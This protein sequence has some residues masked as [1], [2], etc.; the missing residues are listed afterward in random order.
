METGGDSSD[1]WVDIGD[2]TQQER[3]V[4]SPIR[5]VAGAKQELNVTVGMNGAKM[6][7]KRANTSE[8]DSALNSNAQNTCVGTSA[9]MSA[10]QTAHNTLEGYWKSVALPSNASAGDW[11]MCYKPHQ[12]IWSTVLS[13]H[14][15]LSPRPAIFPTIAVVD[16]TT[17]FSAVGPTDNGD[18]FLLSPDGC[19]DQAARGNVTIFKLLQAGVTDI[20]FSGTGIAFCRFHFATLLLVNNF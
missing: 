10:S 8:L 7:W 16:T 9:V 2:W 13:R 1:D 15:T 18:I 19:Q 4:F 6:F 11:I 12:G 5:T 14:L 3:P 17:T 20:L